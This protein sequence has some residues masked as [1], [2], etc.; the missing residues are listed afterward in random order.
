MPR[1]A[2]R[3]SGAGRRHSTQAVEHRSTEPRVG[4]SNLSGRATRSGNSSKTSLFAAALL[5]RGVPAADVRR[6]LS[7]FRVNVERYHR[8]RISLRA[9]SAANDALAAR[10]LLAY[11]ARVSA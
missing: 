10:L 11:P 9:L 8:R 6:L 5:R 7:A 4:S 3:V 1:S 2:I